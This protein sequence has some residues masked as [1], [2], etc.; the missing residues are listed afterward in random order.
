MRCLDRSPFKDTTDIS[1][2]AKRCLE[3]INAEWYMMMAARELVEGL[4]FDPM[5]FT[6]LL[7]FSIL[8]IFLLRFLHMKM[9]ASIHKL[10]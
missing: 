8:L 4:S 3:R 10:C 7:I 2:L 6:K 5:C 1:I 9:L